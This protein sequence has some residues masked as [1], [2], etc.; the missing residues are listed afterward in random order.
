MPLDPNFLDIIENLAGP[1][2]R[3][4]GLIDKE[5]ALVDFIY[6]KLFEYRII[7]HI[8]GQMINMGTEM[9][10]CKQIDEL[11]SQIGDMVYDLPGN[12]KEKRERELHSLGFVLALSGMRMRRDDEQIRQFAEEYG[13]KNDFLIS[14][15]MAMAARAIQGQSSSDY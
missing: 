15:F 2:R 5:H 12:T 14:T 4:A 8:E 11:E 13:K 7:L 10:C 6:P 3:Q 1:T 9:Y